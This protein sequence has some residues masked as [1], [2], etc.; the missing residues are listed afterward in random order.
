MVL[1]VKNMTEVVQVAVEVRSIP[2][3]LQWVQEHSLA[4]AAA[5]I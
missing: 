3:R 4:E 2:D 5:Q 1:W